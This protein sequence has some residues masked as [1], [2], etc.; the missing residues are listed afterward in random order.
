[1]PALRVYIGEDGR[2]PEEVLDGEAAA[3][4]GADQV[5]GLRPRRLEMPGDRRSVA[6]TAEEDPLGGRRVGDSPGAVRGNENDVFLRDGLG[7]ILVGERAVVVA[8]YPR[9]VLLSSAQ[10]V[11]GAELLPQLLGLLQAC[12]GEDLAG[13]VL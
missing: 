6:Q 12:N 3:G 4:S 10:N 1:M 8:L 5:D 2:S 9:G 13:P 11:R 7:W